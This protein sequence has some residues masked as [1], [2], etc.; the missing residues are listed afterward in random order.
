MQRDQVKAAGGSV[1]VFP[2]EGA[3]PGFRE[4]PEERV[5]D[6]RRRV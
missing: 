2:K 5:K 6:T 4:S 1:E 3:C